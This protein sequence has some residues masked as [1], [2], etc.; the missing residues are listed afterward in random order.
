MNFKY[1]TLALSVSLAL[2]GCGG[3]DDNDDKIRALENQV[4]ALEEQN[5]AEV[6]ELQERLDELTVTDPLLGENLVQEANKLS[7]NNADNV[8]RFAIF[9]D[10]QGRDDD[11]MKV[12]VCVDLEGNTVTD[13]AYPTAD[14][15]TEAREVCEWI[16][17]D[18]NNDGYY[19]AGTESQNDNVKLGDWDEDGIS[20]LVN[21][22]D[23]FHPFIETEDGNPVIVAPEDRKDY[24]PDWK[25]LP[26]P[27]VEAVTDKIIELDV[28][29]V[30]AIG[31]MTEYRAESDYVQWMDKVATPL[32]EAGISIFPVRGNH[33]IVNGRNWLAWFNNEQEWERQSVNNVYNDI[34]PYE[35]FDAGDYDQGARLYR[36]YVGELTQTHLNEGKAI[37]FPGAEDLNYYFIHNNTL[38]IAIDFYFGDLY[39][40][41]YKGTW[42][43]LN[44][45]LEETIKSNAADVEHIVVYGHEALSSKKRPITYDVKIYEEYVALE[46]KLRTEVD[47]ARADYDAA[48]AAAEPAETLAILQAALENAVEALEE[49]VEPTLEG[50]DIGQLGYLLLQDESEPGLAENILSLFTEYQV[51]YIS[52]HDHQYSRS[53]IHS[54][55]KHKDSANGFTQIIGG[56]ASWKAYEGYYGFHQE[57]E[58]GLFLD[59]YVRDSSDDQDDLQNSNGET[60]SS[61]TDDLGDGI[62][63]VVVEING[64][65]ITTTAY[66]ASHDL[67]EVDMNVGA[68]YDYETNQWCEYEGDYLV[69]DSTPTTKVC[70]D[71]EW[72]KV[73]ENTRTTDA[74]SR[75]VE[76][77]Q[78]YF[79]QSRTPEVDGYIGS[80]ASIFDGYNMTFDSFHASAVDR[81]EMLRELV[82]MSWFTDESDITLTDILLISG[83]QTQDGTHHNS[84]GKVLEGESESITYINRSGCEVLNAT[85]VTRDG[86]MN[87]GTDIEV[88]LSGDT[89]KT[90]YEAGCSNSDSWD[91]RY[92]D[93]N[94]DFADAM[95]LGF[96]APEGVDIETLT[97]GRYDE[98]TEQ[99]VP[100]F[101]EECFTDTGYS[102]HYS[103]HYRISEQ[104]PEGGFGV[105]NCQQRYWGYHKESNSIW[106][107][108]HTDGKFAVI[109]K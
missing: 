86:V 10:S 81:I 45:W 69:N 11:N 26:V 49:N 41:A 18:F 3:N 73:D 90:D 48:I 102:E 36:S 58:T 64:R 80:E 13:P 83:N 70:T 35:G 47:V 6:T 21:V 1:K 92:Q 71:I 7:E 68:H 31:D 60:I 75:V 39:S 27:M 24:G 22:S 25:I 23:P 89:S 84:Y 97:V 88:S 63:F 16:G 100:A 95:T 82:S 40:S 51:T 44:E 30:L 74:I 52:G 57:L 108:I 66:F 56:N 79:L 2:A 77:E 76:P 78:N 34:N 93:N 20:Y 109:A 19:D 85:H 33:E 99:W 8:W 96:T 42:V 94:L 104:E 29:I 103:V 12:S 72:V 50:L 98:A 28:D 15:G 61:P 9:P 54:D 53:L 67:T 101:S 65:Q 14:G 32:T 43:A 4:A 107:F 38:F 105:D 5:D 87:K 55:P 37:G 91:N 59:N 46:A 106:G 17:V 62:S